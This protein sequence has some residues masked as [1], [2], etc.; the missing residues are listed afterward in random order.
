[1]GFFVYLLRDIQGDGIS[2]A[3]DPTVKRSKGR[4]S[5]SVVGVTVEDITRQYP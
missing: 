3:S 5:T 4:T 2:S 1:M